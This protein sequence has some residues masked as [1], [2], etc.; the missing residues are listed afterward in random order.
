MAT[1]AQSPTSDEAVAGTWTGTAGTRYQAVDD[2]PDTVPTDYLAHGTAAGSL[3]FGFSA[4]AIPP[5]ATGISVAVRYY[6]AE[7]AN[8]SN[9]SASRIK[10]G[11][12]YYN[13]ATHNPSGTTYTTRTDTWATNPKTVAAWT[14]DD[15]NGVGANALQAFGF[16]S[17]DANPVYRVSCVQ[18]EV[19]YTPAPVTLAGTAAGAAATTGA[20][21]VAQSLAGASTG[22]TTTTGAVRIARSLA[23][24]AQ[25]VTAT[26][27]GL[28][29]VGIKLLAG[30]ASG[31]ATA[32][33]ALSVTR[34]LAGTSQGVAGTTG[35]LRVT[36]G[37]SGLATA[38]ATAMASLTVTDGQAVATVMRSRG[39]LRAAMR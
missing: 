16:Y 12:T 24:T 4:F 1:Q 28:T 3:T 13:S 32:Q 25:G 20:I 21:R 19:T 29:V 10:V 31:V 5:G 8:G 35:A 2:Y 23:G 39:M 22:V 18:L 36:R 26:T 11:G 33:A 6:D 30:I 7:P 37:L 38:A 9:Q 15:V 34:A 17:G 14:V 27:A